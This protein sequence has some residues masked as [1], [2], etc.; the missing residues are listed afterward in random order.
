MVVS[1][2]SRL[3]ATPPSLVDRRWN[4]CARN[5]FAEAVSGPWGHTLL[6]STEQRAQDELE[7]APGLGPSSPP[8]VLI[9]REVQ[10]VLLGIGLLLL[11]VAARAARHV[12]LVFIVASLI[13]L[14]LNPLVAFIHRRR[15][16]RGLAILLVYLS[17]LACVVAIGYALSSPISNQ[18]NNFEHAVPGLVKSANKHLSDLQNFFNKHGIHVQIKKQGQ[19]ALQTL[20][21]K[22]AKGSSSLVSFSGSLLKSAAN[23][24]ISLVLIFVLSVY[25]LV[26]AQRIGRVVRAAMPRGDG[27]PKDDYPTAV[28]RAVSSYV[29]GQLLFSLTMGATAGVALFLFGLIGIFPDGRTYAIAFGVFYGVM[30]LI[31]Y[32]GP[33][34]GALPPIAVALF[35]H[36]ITAVWV[37][38]L[39]IAIQQLEGHIVAP[40]IFG[41]ALRINPVLVILA[42][43]FG[44]AVYGIV[45]AIVA[46]PLAAVLRETIIYLRRH[47]VL[48]SWRAARPAP[49]D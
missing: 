26:Y 7:Q 17:L 42:L 39:L 13:A 4:R 30:E 27:T 31:P 11:W 8:P 16:P 29:R 44:D 14:L 35:Q 25:M 24:V 34:L 23:A 46:L 33:V 18:V 1:A 48:E 40:Q 38:I 22:V 5:H 28:Q 9:P 36:P 15:V 12:V 49:P 32:L 19:T 47:V 37:T 6:V 10:L 43:L 41:H 21:G 2:P 20:A 45:G 3:D